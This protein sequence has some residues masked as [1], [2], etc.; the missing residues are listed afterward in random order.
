MEG[1]H[2]HLGPH[3]A[4]EIQMGRRAH[5]LHRDHIRQRRIGMDAPPDDVQEIHQPRI[6]EP[7]RHLDPLIGRDAAGLVLIGHIAHAQ[8]ELR[9]HPLTAG[10]QHLHREP[11]PVVQRS[12]IRPLRRRGQRA[13][14]LV[15]QMAVT[16]EFHPI[17]TGRLH[18]FRRIGIVADDPRDIPIL[19]NLG[20]GPMRRFARL[21][22]RQHRQPV[23]L[24]PPRPPPKMAD[25]DHHRRACLVAVIGQP[26]HPR[27]DLILPDQHIAERGRAV[28]AHAGRSRRHHHRHSGPRP[29]QMIQAIAILRHPVLGIG[30][31]MARRH[32][33]VAQGQM[34]Q[35]VRLQQGIVRHRLG[36]RAW[37]LMGSIQQNVH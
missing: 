37:R 2:P 25:L 26:P 32:D 11:H 12:G 28:P 31:F 1:G 17:Q 20:K 7:P 30:R 27:H 23:A 18:P 24:V 35:P 3:T 22:R 8:Q 14:E 19:D 36:L 34:L 29:L 33:P 16:F 13:D 9:S 15:H 10:G 21:P 5:P 4:R 6:P